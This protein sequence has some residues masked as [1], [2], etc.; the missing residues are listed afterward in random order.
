MIFTDEERFNLEG[1][2]GL[3][4]YYHDLRKEQQLPSRRSMGGDGITIWRDIG[5]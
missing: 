4:C 2:D 5:Y 3:H 1:P